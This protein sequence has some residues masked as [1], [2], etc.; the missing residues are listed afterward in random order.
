M[1]LPEQLFFQPGESFW[2]AV[3][4]N[5]IT[6]E[7][8]NPYP[9]GLAFS[10]AGDVS[11]NCYMSNDLGK[12]WSRLD[13]ALKGSPYESMTSE[14]TWAIDPKSQNPDWS[15]LL[16]L[17]P[18]EGT[19]VKGET[20]EVKVT[21]STSKLINGTYKFNIGFKT[22]ETADNTLRQAVTMTVSG[23]KAEMQVP[24]IVDFGSLLVGETKK[25]TVE[26]YNKGYGDFRGS[27]Y[28][29]GIYSDKISVSSENFAG[30]DYV[31]AGFPARA[32][33]TVELT[34]QPKTAG[35]HTGTVTFT[36]KDG[37]TFRITMRG[38]ATD[39]AKLR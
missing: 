6:D 36:D 32:K 26:I 27:Q 19:V 1:A 14:Y 5:P 7:V 22:N 24:R 11:H 30:P 12:T 2:I 29:A 3:H 17:T 18:S 13:E 38:V 16:V 25:L 9:L 20:Q 28:S 23:N 8:Y 33:A 15:E 34:Y 39:P 35:D 4:F 10:N 31:S 37:D 21:S